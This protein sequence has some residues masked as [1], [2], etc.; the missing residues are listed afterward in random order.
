MFDED[1]TLNKTE[2]EYS[3]ILPTNSSDQKDVRDFKTESRR[4]T[5]EY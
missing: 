2:E 3:W 1:I 4:R 5:K